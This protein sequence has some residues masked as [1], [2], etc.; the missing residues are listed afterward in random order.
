MVASEWYNY[1][2]LFCFGFSIILYTLKIISKIYFLNQKTSST[3][4]SPEQHMSGLQLGNARPSN[5]IGQL[6]QYFAGHSTCHRTS[7]L[8]WATPHLRPRHLVKGVAVAAAQGG[9]S[10]NPQSGPP[11]G[12]RGWRLV[13]GPL[14]ATASPGRWPGSRAHEVRK[15]AGRR[16]LGK[17]K[18]D[19]FQQF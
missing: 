15:A 11:S 1:I 14:L 16:E 19:M 6:G 3:T 9:A 12:A 2:F 10:P 8:T 17:Y 18:P 7:G 5:L 4:P 13:S